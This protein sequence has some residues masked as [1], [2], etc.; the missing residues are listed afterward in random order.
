MF[1]IL[2]DLTNGDKGS[3]AET[4]TTEDKIPTE[5]EREGELDFIQF[6]SLVSIYIN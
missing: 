6:V 1:D 4:A 3:P 2:Q 5:Q